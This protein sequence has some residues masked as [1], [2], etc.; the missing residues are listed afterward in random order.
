MP[1][2]IFK[3]AQRTDLPSM[4]VPNTAAFLADIHVS[5]DSEKPITCGF[6]RME[7]GK[8][9]IYDYSYEEM[10][11]IVEGEMIITDENGRRAHVFPGDVLY[12]A[13]GSRIQFESPSY[14]IGF[15]CGQRK[16]GEA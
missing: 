13:K 4:N 1:L 7:H 10:K 3:N 6:F 5:N 15:F 2:T 14:G 16:W 9:L 12:F 11:I 8:A